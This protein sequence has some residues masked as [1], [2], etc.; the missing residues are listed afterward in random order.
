MELAPQVTPLSV[1]LTQLTPQV[2]TLFSELFHPET[3]TIDREALIGDPSLT[4][5]E[6]EEYRNIILGEAEG[7]LGGTFFEAFNT[8]KKL[9][10][11]QI[12]NIVAHKDMLKG[13]REK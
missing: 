13:L 10:I 11:D 3:R 8:S 5:E 4:P 1:E 12:F 6:L 2:T 7:G 9:L